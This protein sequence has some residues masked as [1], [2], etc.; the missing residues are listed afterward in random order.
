MTHPRK[1]M[2]RSE[3]GSRMPDCRQAVGLRDD[4][5]DGRKKEG[6]RGC[7]SECTPLHTLHNH[8]V[9]YLVL[10]YIFNMLIY[11]Y[12]IPSRSSS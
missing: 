2:P 8:P 4:K 6:G 12:I 10:Q 9:D 3:T 1:G 7:E 11:N 5:V